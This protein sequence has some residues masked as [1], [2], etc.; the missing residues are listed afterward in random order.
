MRWC[1]RNEA[2]WSSVLTPSEYEWVNS[3]E[4]NSIEYKTNPAVYM[5]TRWMVQL[6]M[7]LTEQINY[8]VDL[9]S[10]SNSDN[11][12]D[13]SPASES[14]NE[15]SPDSLSAAASVIIRMATA[16][17]R[18]T[19]AMVIGVVFELCYELK[20]KHINWLDSV[21]FHDR[22]TLLC[23][24]RQWANRKEGFSHMLDLFSPS[25]DKCELLL[26]EQ[27]LIALINRTT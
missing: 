24:R 5:P 4:Q 12:E 1:D 22:P 9:W 20:R 14:V 23:K 21:R 18:I 3:G 19:S 7:I 25:N 10:A 11:D 27:Y 2:R 17:G 16:N 15:D 13:Q 8:F 26:Q 6:L